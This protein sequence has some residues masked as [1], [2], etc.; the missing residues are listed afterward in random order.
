MSKTR[1]TD[2]LVANGEIGISAGRS[3]IASE[4]LAKKIPAFV[5]IQARPVS[6]THLDVYKRQI[7]VCVLLHF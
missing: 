7:M 4:I 2:Y 5:F 3:K 6:Y 1:L